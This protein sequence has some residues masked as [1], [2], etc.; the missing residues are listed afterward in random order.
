MKLSA[1]VKYFRK[2]F[3]KERSLCV[4]SEYRR[5]C[6]IAKQ[7]L[8]RQL[9]SSDGMNYT[10][11]FYRLQ[12][13]CQTVNSYSVATASA[14]PQQAQGKPTASPQQA[15]GQRKASPQQAQGQRKA[16][17]RQ[18]QGQRKATDRENEN[19]PIYKRQRLLE[20]RN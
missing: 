4:C 1:L 6:Q 3:V 2:C 17:P 16:S 7:S 13:I 11:S 19:R 10:E 20:P 8:L 14:S 12:A 5:C 9:R 18:A 15:Q